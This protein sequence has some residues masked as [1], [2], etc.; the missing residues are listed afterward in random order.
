MADD[1]LEERY[2]R[3]DLPPEDL[4][5]TLEDDDLEDLDDLDGARPLG[6]IDDEEPFG[7]GR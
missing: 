4:E 6:V 3:N 5:L 2:D 7:F 1:S